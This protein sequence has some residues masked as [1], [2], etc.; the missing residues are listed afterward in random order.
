MHLYCQAKGK[1]RC[2]EQ[3]ARLR[4][5]RSGRRHRRRRRGQR[6]LRVVEAA[7]RRPCGRRRRP[8]RRRDRPAPDETYG[9]EPAWPRPGAKGRQWIDFQNDVTVKDIELAAREN[10]RSVEHLK[11]YTT[12]GMATDQG[13]TSN[14]N[15]LAAMAV[16]T[17]RSIADT[18]TTT[19]RPPFVPVP[20]TIV[21]GPPA[22]RA[23]QPGAPAGARERAPRRRRRV[24]RIWRL[25]APRLLWRRV[26][27][28]PKS[29]AKR[30]WRATRWRSSTARRSARS[31]CWGRMPARWSTT[32]PTTPCPAWPGRIRYGFM[33]TEAGVVYRRR[34][35]VESVRP[36]LHRLV[37]VG[38]CRG[39]RACGSKNGGRTASI[40]AVSSSTIRRPHWA[41]L[42]ASGPRVARSGRRSRSR[43][44]PRRCRAAA[45][46][47]RRLPLPGQAGACRPRQ[48]SPAIA[49]TRF[50]C[51]SSQAPA[52]WQAMNEIARHVEW[53]R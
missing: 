27:P 17:G 51:A 20:F 14:M 8:A 35:R 7:G 39:R 19:Y 6:H 50:P 38:P 53:R 12:L 18:G 3:L 25:A 41:T 49:A 30:G 34:R 29:S 32:I 44:R 23:V 36:A 42:T 45:H 21:A 37:L 24:P 33:L 9:V 47:V 4:S 31:R 28:T 26:T 2:D 11:R 16:I 52:L 48:L 5:R 43:R 15:G 46:G 10:F 40:R 22:R 13:K 1:L